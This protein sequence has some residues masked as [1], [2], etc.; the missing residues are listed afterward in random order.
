MARI[1]AVYCSP[2]LLQ[3]E[4]V[5]CAGQSVIVTVACIFCLN[6]ARKEYLSI[7]KY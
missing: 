6:E 1:A 3:A 4:V 5:K 7:V 2:T